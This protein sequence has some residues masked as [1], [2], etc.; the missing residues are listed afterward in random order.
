[1]FG[2]SAFKLFS[3][4]TKKIIR[5]IDDDDKKISKLLKILGK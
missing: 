4:D 1:M 3:E 2:L 5:K